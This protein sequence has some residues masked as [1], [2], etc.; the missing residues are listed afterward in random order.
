[1]YSYYE[2]DTYAIRNSDTSNLGRLFLRDLCYMIMIREHSTIVKGNYFEFA[3][4][5]ALCTER[6]TTVYNM[7][8]C[9]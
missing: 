4:R 1:M 2:S 8:D 5:C 7:Q 3:R 6:F 9:A